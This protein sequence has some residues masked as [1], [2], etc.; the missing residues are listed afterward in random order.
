MPQ[1][2]L[3]PVDLRLRDLAGGV[4]WRDVQP[5][6]GGPQRVEIRTAQRRQAHVLG[7]EVGAGLG[8]LELAAQPAEAGGQALD[9]LGGRVAPVLPGVHV[10]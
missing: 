10:L 9:R 3:H 1:R 2:R 5:F 6:A 8:V 7:G 4:R